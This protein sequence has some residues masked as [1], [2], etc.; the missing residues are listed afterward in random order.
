MAVQDNSGETGGELLWQEHA[1]CRGPLGSV[2]FPPPTTERKREKIAREQK[3]KEICKA[4]PVLAPCRQY[5]I[6]IR[7]PHG[8][9]GG[10]SEKERRVLL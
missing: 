7:E 6:E 5:S 9:W 8:V 1:A 10:L 3:A 4:C 2:F